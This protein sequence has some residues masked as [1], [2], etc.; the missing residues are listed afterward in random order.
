M[1][2]NG[3]SVKE[4]GDEGAVP[5]PNYRP[6]QQ[7]Q[8]ADGRTVRALTKSAGALKCPGTSIC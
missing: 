1:F 4:S 6:D 5:R 2:E 3:A 8:V 7:F